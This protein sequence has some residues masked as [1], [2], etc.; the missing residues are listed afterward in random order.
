MIRRATAALGIGLFV[1]VLAVAAL[2]AGCAAAS[3]VT[4]PVS[5]KTVILTNSSNGSSV[6]ASKGE[7]VVV[8]LSGGHVRWSEAQAIQS[9]PVLVRVSGSTSTTGSSKTT[10]RVANYGT[11]ELDATGR[12][13]CNPA[14]GCPQYVLSWHATVIVPVLDPPAPAAG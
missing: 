13:I 11:A 9:T 1:S 10:F 12:P 6:I 4:F 5:T 14:G 2:C 3:T 7:L 8:K